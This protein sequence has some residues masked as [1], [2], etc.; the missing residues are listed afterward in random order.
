MKLAKISPRFIVIDYAVYHVINYDEGIT[1]GFKKG[2]AYLVETDYMDIV[3]PFKGILKDIDHEKRTPG[4]YTSRKNPKIHRFLLPKGN[5]R[6]QFSPKNIKT[7]A[8]DIFSKG[9]FVKGD[10][11]IDSDGEVF[12]PRIKP[13]DDLNLKLLKAAINLKNI[14]LSS[15]DNRFQAID[16]GTNPSNRKSNA[17]KAILNNDSLSSN[18]MVQLGDVMDL[19]IAVVIKDKPSSMYPMNTNGKPI[20]L[21][22]GPVFSLEGAV[23]VATINQDSLYEVPEE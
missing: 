10:I 4:I 11:I 1:K 17:K 14:S 5:D 22:S 7:T 8:D 6:D 3:L 16:I 20:V 2:V 21:Y 19:D 9:N 13:D 18:K 23:N 12:K 15:Y